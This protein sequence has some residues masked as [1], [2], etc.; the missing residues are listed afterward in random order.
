MY[1]CEIIFL[2]IFY[3]NWQEFLR[4]AVSVMQNA[5]YFKTATSGNLP[6]ILFS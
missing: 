1:R 6:K 5:E 4:L 2:E 3:K